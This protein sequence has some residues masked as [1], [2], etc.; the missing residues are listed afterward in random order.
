MTS[1]GDVSGRDKPCTSLSIGEDERIK[2]VLINYSTYVEAIAFITDKGQFQV[3]GTSTSSRS[4]EKAYSFTGDFDFFG[5]V[6]TE[7]KQISS[8]SIIRFKTECLNDFKA[9]MGSDFTYGG[10][11]AQ[12]S[13]GSSSSSE[14]TSGSTSNQSSNSSDDDF[15]DE[16][17]S[18][19]GSGIELNI[20]V[21]A[22]MSTA[23]EHM[24]YTAIAGGVVLLLL[25]ICCICCCCRCC[26]KKNKTK[27]GD[28]ETLSEATANIA[29]PHVL[30]HRPSI[31]PRPGHNINARD[32][33]TTI[34]NDFRSSDG[35]AN[36]MSA[37]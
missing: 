32:T 18:E 2:S 21:D 19:S 23:M 11:G 22:I 8:V 1:F 16:S 14:T 4:S 20:D 28:V 36:G 12:A 26:C 15:D 17:D 30:P 31:A 5:L 10:D 6:G 35:N 7:T 9:S 34:E 13:S 25:F 27:I 24:L 33:R 37:L 29:S 3:V